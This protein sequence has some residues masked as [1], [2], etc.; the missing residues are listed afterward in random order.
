MNIGKRSELVEV[1]LEPIE[2][3]AVE[4][5]PVQPEPVVALE[6]EAVPA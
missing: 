4:P 3:P 6:P 2:G 5:A 1:E